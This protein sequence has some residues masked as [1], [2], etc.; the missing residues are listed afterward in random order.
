MS[1]EPTDNPASRPPAQAAPDERD[2]TIERL[3]R[4][5][6]EER[7][8]SAT[9][10]ETVDGL[11][12]KTEVLE[13]GYS[14]QLADARLRCEKA[15]RELAELKTQLATLGSGGEETLRLLSETR[16]EL[17]QITAERDRLHKQ[18]GL[19]QRPQ[20]KTFGKIATEAPEDGGTINALIGDSSWVRD[21]QAAADGHLNAQVRAD[22][23]TPPV[24]M[25]APDLVFTKDEDDEDE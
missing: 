6:A 15:E 19:S 17:A 22:Q 18:L 12:F 25:I 9:L 21:R 7:Q 20:T 8:N 14:K 10:R 16:A 3:D 11:H 23:D 2:A 24:E 1:D 4:A 5:L 13:K